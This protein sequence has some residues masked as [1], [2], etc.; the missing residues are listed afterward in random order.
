VADFQF[1][2]PE[3]TEALKQMRELTSRRISPY[4]K[5]VYIDGGE[6]VIFNGGSLRCLSAPMLQSKIAP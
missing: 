6:D 1:A 4:A 2:Q 5:V 3:I